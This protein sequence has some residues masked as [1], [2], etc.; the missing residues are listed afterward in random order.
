MTCV[1]FYEFACWTSRYTLYTFKYF[2]DALTVIFNELRDIVFTICSF[3]YRHSLLPIFEFTISNLPKIWSALCHLADIT[4]MTMI[5][6]LQQ[7]YSGGKVLYHHIRHALVKFL[8]TMFIHVVEPVVRA[9]NYIAPIVWSKLKQFVLYMAHGIRYIYSRVCPIV[10]I[11]YRNVRPFAV[12]AYSAIRIHFIAAMKRLINDTF[13]KMWFKSKQFLIKIPSGIQRIYVCS[14]RTL[15]NIY[16]S[17]YSLAVI[18]CSMIRTRFMMLMG[19]F[20]GG[21]MRTVWSKLKEL[22]A[23]VTNGIWYI[24]GMIHPL[25]I[26]VYSTVRTY[27]TMYYIRQL[28]DDI[29]PRVWYKS[30]Q[31]LI[32]TS[33]G[34]RY[35]Y[36][37][38]RAILPYI[39]DIVY[40][41]AIVAFCTVKIHL[42]DATRQLISSLLPTMWS[43]SRQLV[44]DMINGIRHVYGR[45]CHRGSGIFSRIRSFGTLV[46]S[47]IHSEFMISTIRSIRENTAAIWHSLGDL[48]ISVKQIAPRIRD[49]L[50]QTFRTLSTQC[51]TMYGW[52]KTNVLVIC[53]TLYPSMLHVTRYKLNE[54][55]Q[56]VQRSVVQPM[57]SLSFSI[58][59]FI[60]SMLNTCR[61]FISSVRRMMATIA[62]IIVSAKNTVTSHLSRQN[63]TQT[64]VS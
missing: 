28:I 13:P 16:R 33:A 27:L 45:L 42:V 56:I 55:H 12:N 57:I 48:M 23:Y 31:L 64:V 59:V 21:T 25:V 40:T 10:T 58:R 9:A 8:S 6:I 22:V 63:R 2:Y 51:F 1:S 18:V 36:G 61:V 7:L 15:A 35:V 62:L 50:Y 32:K 52:I 26:K 4:T 5:R 19:R 14:Y 38:L 44:V 49:N 53:R 24:Y 46:Y 11:I 54:F 37:R 3:I 17:A 47:I 20:T 39:Y 30:K 43:K 41:F 60:S 29:L 34:V